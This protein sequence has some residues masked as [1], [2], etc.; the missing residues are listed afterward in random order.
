METTLQ[1]RLNEALE[2]EY[3]ARATYQKVIE[4]FGAVRPFSNI[5]E[6]EERHVAA[7]VALFRSHGCAIP[8]DHWPEKVQAPDTLEEACRRGLEAE[9]ENMGMYERLLATTAEPDVRRVLENLQSAS[10][11]HH[12]PAFERC[13]AR[14][15]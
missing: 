1:D 4:K 14:R 10:R 15:T 9:K 13:L 12:L 8:D 5:L 6:A 7:L 2:D 11:D 3:K